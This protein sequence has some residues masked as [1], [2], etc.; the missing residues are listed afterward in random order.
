MTTRLAENWIPNGGKEKE[1]RIKRKVNKNLLHSAGLIFPMFFFISAQLIEKK[2][3]KG[4]NI[5]FDITK[6]NG[7]LNGISWYLLVSLKTLQKTFHWKDI[8]KLWKK[9]KYLQK[10]HQNYHLQIILQS[11]IGIRSFSALKSA[12]ISAYPSTANSEPAQ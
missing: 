8:S 5:F 7:F 10:L 4:P 6:Q 11:W 2:W 12:V 3:R 1:R 9:T